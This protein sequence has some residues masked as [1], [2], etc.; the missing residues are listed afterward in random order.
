MIF[1]VALDRMRAIVNELGG[2]IQ[3]K[4]ITPQGVINSEFYII[5]KGESEAA[6]GIYSNV[7]G[8]LSGLAVDVKNTGYNKDYFK[9]TDFKLVERDGLYHLFVETD[10]AI[11]H[12][13]IITDKIREGE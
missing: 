4:C 5:G 2:A 10:G 6:L 9:V 8:N 3:D 11:L 7:E 12:E 13:S 1:E